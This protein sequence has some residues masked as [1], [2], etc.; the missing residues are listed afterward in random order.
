MVITNFSAFLEFWPWQESSLVFTLDAVYLECMVQPAQE[1][2][3]ETP[4]WLL[5]VLLMSGT[6][7]AGVQ[8]G[9]SFPA[10]APAQV[11]VPLLCP[12]SPI[13][14]LSPCPS[15]AFHTSLPLNG[16]DNKSYY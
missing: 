2:D 1:T 3:P 13:S 12:T 11:R 6:L 10:L 16:G 15:L 14:P 4:P 8:A 7:C 5:L 9:S